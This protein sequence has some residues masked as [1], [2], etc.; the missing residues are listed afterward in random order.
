MPLAVFCPLVLPWS[1][2]REQAV[3]LKLKVRVRTSI[4]QSELTLSLCSFVLAGHCLSGEPGAQG[5]Q[6]GPQDVGDTSWCTF[7]LALS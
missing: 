2:F 4:M 1:S 7:C 6:V 3:G 5:L